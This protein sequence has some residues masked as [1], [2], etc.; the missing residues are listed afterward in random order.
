MI[1]R[2]RAGG[3]RIEGWEEKKKIESKD[4]YLVRDTYKENY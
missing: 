2:D 3:K 4:I 1:E